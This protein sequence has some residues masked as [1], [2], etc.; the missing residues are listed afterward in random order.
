V[1]SSESEH[2]THWTD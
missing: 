1:I 2:T